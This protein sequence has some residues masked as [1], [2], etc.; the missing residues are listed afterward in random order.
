V[1]SE[2]IEPHYN[3]IFERFVDPDRPEVEQLPGIVAYGLYKI[4]KREWAS[5]LSN[6]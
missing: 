6:V 3:P 4:A 5:E 2:S 1:T